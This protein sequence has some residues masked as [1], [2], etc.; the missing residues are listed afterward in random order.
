MLFCVL[1]SMLAMLLFSEMTLTTASGFL[2]HK[3]QCRAEAQITGV[4]VTAAISGENGTSKFNRSNWCGS[5]LVWH[6]TA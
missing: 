1:R 6:L 4:L 5:A 2:Y 3:R